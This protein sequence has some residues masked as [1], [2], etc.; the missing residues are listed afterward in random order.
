MH[1]LKFITLTALVLL[2]NTACSNRAEAAP[3][4]DYPAQKV[5]TRVWVILGPTEL[6]NPK[7]QGFMNNPGIVLTTQGAV[8]VDPGSTLET[9]EMV[10]RVL[11][12]ITPQPVVAVFNTHVHGDHWL[13]NQAIVN[14]YPNVKIFAHPEMIAE[15]KNG[16]ADF[17]VKLMYTMTKGASKGT[18]A[19]IPNAAVQNGESIKIGDTD[20]RIY[21]NKQ[22]HTKTDIMIEVVQDRLMFLGDN[23]GNQR[24]LRINDGSFTGDIAAIDMAL[25]TNAIYFIPG[26]GPGG[27]KAVP[28]DYRRYLTAVYLSAKQAFENNMD[29]SDVRPIAEKNTVAFK[30]WSGYKDEIGRQ[31]VQAYAEVEAAEF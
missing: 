22:A 19:V 12:K 6:P 8:I 13:G 17:W 27:T 21:H 20:F 3:V 28:L 4:P 26:H 9:G 31:G 10:L 5:S 1:Y 25:A 24:I 2:L 29:S 15:A 11:K 18:V 30:N 14:A 23:V 16:A 7:N